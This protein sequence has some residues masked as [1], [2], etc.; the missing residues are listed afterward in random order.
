MGSYGG[1]D[2][3][4]KA[5]ER[6]SDDPRVQEAGCWVLRELTERVVAGHAKTSFA[7]GLHVVLKALS[8]HQLEPKVQAAA[9]SALRKMAAHDCDGS[10]RTTCL[11]RCG[12]LGQSS[13]MRALSA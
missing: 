11:G 12:R 1:F 3:A 2:A 7:A 5:M 10:V 4:Q 9:S 13:A 6:H 8:R